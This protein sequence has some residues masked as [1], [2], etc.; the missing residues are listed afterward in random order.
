MQFPRYGAFEPVFRAKKAY[1]APAVGWFQEEWQQ[2]LSITCGIMAIT[3]LPLIAS[4]ARR[5]VSD[6]I[7]VSGD[8]PGWRQFKFANTISVRLVGAPNC[9]AVLVFGPPTPSY[10]EWNLGSSVSTLWLS[11]HAGSSPHLRPRDQFD[12]FGPPLPM[13]EL[14]LGGPFKVSDTV[15]GQ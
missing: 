2:T 5:K 9:V 8:Q 4:T 3:L 7:I 13:P 10:L 6:Q 1:L 15:G 11:D 12:L 14:P